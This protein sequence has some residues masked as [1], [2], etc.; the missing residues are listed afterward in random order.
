MPKPVRDDMYMV[1]RASPDRASLARD[2]IYMVGLSTP[3]G[4]VIASA[5]P[6]NI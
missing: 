3:T 5:Y 6:L 1:G 4:L 2:D